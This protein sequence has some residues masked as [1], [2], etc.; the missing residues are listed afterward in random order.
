[1]AVM[2][3]EEKAAVHFLVLMEAMMVAEETALQILVEV[4]ADIDMTVQLTSLEDRALV[5][6][7]L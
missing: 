3:A 6:L 4:G 2:A 5:A 7:E 1:M